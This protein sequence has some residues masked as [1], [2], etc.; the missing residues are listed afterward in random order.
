MFAGIHEFYFDKELYLLCCP[1]KVP[2]MFEGGLAPVTLTATAVS[3][4]TPRTNKQKKV[5]HIFSELKKNVGLGAESN[6]IQILP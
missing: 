6:I 1:S 4:Q 5:N 3:V 2:Q